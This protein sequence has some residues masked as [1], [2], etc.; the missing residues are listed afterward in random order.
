MSES[1]DRRRYLV[2]RTLGTLL[3]HFPVQL[4]VR[5]AEVAAWCVAFRASGT[6]STHERNLRQIL[7]IGSERPADDAVV[8]RWVRRSYGSYGRYWA[9][10]STLPGAGLGIAH[11]RVC[12][13]EGL[14][15]LDRAIASG[16]GA[17]IVLPHEGSWEWG[18]AFLTRIGYPMTAVAEILE[19]R[20]LFEW[21][22]SKRE[23]IGLRVIPLDRSAGGAILNVLRTGGLIGLLADRDITGD[24]ID[25]VLLDHRARVPAGPA[26]LALR[27]GAVL[28]PGVIYSGPGRDHIVRFAPPIDTERTGRL[29]Q[30]VARVTQDVADV[31]S[32]LIRS[33]PEQWHVFEDVFGDRDSGEGT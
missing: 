25:A 30:D 10:G 24:G 14:D 1:S 18:A 16:R 33:H 9:E 12:V 23:A 26:T 3:E 8:R 19:P 6:R 7:E 21:F 13:V 28:L 22:I 15:H 29:R 17:I 2:W 4:A 11:D 31:L 27:S 20:E 32:G 5:V